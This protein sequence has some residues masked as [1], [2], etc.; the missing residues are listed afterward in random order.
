MATEPKSVVPIRL[1]QIGDERRVHAEAI[2]EQAGAEQLDEVMVIGRTNDGELWA[3][4]SLN[5]GQ[6]LW[7]LEK[8]KERVLTGN[9]W[10]IV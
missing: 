7:L 1:T 9:P 2:L 6:S 8:L 3:A 5:S 10:G 4:S